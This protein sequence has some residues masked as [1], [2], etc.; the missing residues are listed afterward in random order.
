MTLLDAHESDDFELERLE[1]I[2]NKDIDELESRFI[3]IKGRSIQSVGSFK[4]VHSSYNVGWFH[5]IKT[6]LTSSGDTRHSA[7]ES[8]QFDHTGDLDGT[9]MIYDISKS[10]A[11][12]SVI[13][14]KIR[15]RYR[16][17]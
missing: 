1:T 16:D 6:E 13:S 8:K 5:A 9:H 4:A 2:D 7:S 11:A 15:Y 17:R 10:D 14:I 3:E 12:D